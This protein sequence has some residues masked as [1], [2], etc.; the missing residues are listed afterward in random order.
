MY[1]L[2]ISTNSWN[3]EMQPYYDYSTENKKTSIN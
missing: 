1:I 3:S 2:N